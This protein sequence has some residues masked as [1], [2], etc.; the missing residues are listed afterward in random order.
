MSTPLSSDVNH[1]EDF[2]VGRRFRHH[3]GRTLSQAESVA[4]AT[5][6]LLHE[7]AQFNRAFAEHNGL[8]DI[9][10]PPVLVFSLVLGMSVEDLS[11]SGGPF[12]GADG[13]EHLLPVHP[14][15]TLYASS[16]VLERRTSTSRPGFGVVR[17]RTT[18]R[19]QGGHTVIRFTR[20]SLVRMRTASRS[21][22]PAGA[23]TCA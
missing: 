14:G 18:G 5:E 6:F 21:A 8:S 20:A 11:E 15:D 19:N 16:E 10:V 22:S 4:F 1:F 3:W 13:I 23:T 2:E 7:P 12:L 9:L 17:W